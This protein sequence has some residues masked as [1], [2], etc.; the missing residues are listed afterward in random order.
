M[1]RFFI[2]LFCEHR[3]VARM[4]AARLM[5]MINAVGAAGESAS[6]ALLRNVAPND[7]TVATP[8]KRNLVSIAAGSAAACGRVSHAVAVQ[9]DHGTGATADVLV[10]ASVGA[11]GISNEAEQS[12]VLNVTARLVNQNEAD[13]M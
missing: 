12:V 7:V 3:R 13:V 6:A 5:M 8:V 1:M 4:A 11:A 10:A 9:A 2:F